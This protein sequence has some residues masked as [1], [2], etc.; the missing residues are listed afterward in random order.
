MKHFIFIAWTFN[1]KFVEKP[2]SFSKLLR[3]NLIS[4]LSNT[5]TKLLFKILIY[6]R[7]SKK[8]PRVSNTSPQVSLLVFP[9]K[10][11]LHILSHTTTRKWNE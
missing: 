5:K 11:P 6:S 8:C 9:S 3:G 4:S 2:K 10:I 1:F 7:K